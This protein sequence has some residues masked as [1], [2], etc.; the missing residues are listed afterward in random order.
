MATTEQDRIPIADV[1]AIEAALGRSLEPA[2][3]ERLE[4]MRALVAEG[5]EYTHVRVVH[6]QPGMT[7]LSRPEIMFVRSRPPRGSTPDEVLA[8]FRGL[9]DATGQDVVRES[10]NGCHSVSLRPERRAASAHRPAAAPGRTMARRRG[11]GT[12]PAARRA[13]ATSASSSSSSDGGDSDPEPEPPASAG[14]PPSLA[15]PS[16]LSLRDARADYAARLYRRYRLH[17]TVAILARLGWPIAARAQALADAGIGQEPG[18]A[19]DRA[20]WRVAQ[21]VHDL[22]LAGCG[23]EELA[24][25]RGAW[26][27]ICPA[28]TDRYRGR[29]LIVEPGEH[30]AALTCAIGCRP[31]AIR[32]AMRER[33]GGAA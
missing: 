9:A 6:P 21:L 10:R 29:R 15:L 30:D 20:R 33:I 16:R 13:R 7:S 2:D 18:P 22:R 8:F 12:R 26:Q 3:V 17:A 27:A 28:C 31:D 24:W 4:G 32:L 1:D 19:P 23:P 5:S 14:R 25:R 11:T